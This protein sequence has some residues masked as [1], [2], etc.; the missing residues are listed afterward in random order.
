MQSQSQNHCFEVGS[1]VW[2]L[3]K[4]EDGWDIEGYIFVAENDECVILSPNPVGYD[5]SI[6]QYLIEESEENDSTDLYVFPK[7][8][9]YAEREDAKAKL[10]KI[11]P[12]AIR[13]EDR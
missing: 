2:I 6:S 9:A 11:Y 1:T 3:R 4:Y 12:E 13:H 5:N 8:Y 10:K 7:R